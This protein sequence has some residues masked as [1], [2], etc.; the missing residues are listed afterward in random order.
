EGAF[1]R[2]RFGLKGE[3][4]S[5]EPPMTTLTLCLTLLATPAADPD[6]AAR[7]ALALAVAARPVAPSYEALRA[8]AVAENR[9]LVVWVGL[10]RPDLERPDWLHPHCD[11]SPGATP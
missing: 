2:W 10:R 7:A 4:S 1:P 11:P 6:A 8:R 3:P 9:P 5:K